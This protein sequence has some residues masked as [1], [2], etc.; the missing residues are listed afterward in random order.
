MDAAARLS[1]TI[2]LDELDRARIRRG[3]TQDQLAKA[4][5][6]NPG[7]ISAM[8]ARRRRPT[9][10]TLAALCSALGLE[11]SDVISLA[12]TGDGS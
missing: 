2:D 7:T 8:F 10:G 4:S 6:V 1:W 5:R 9:F 11:L 12:G 3:W